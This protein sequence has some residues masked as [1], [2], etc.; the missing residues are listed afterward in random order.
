[1]IKVN[2][3]EQKERKKESAVSIFWTGGYDSTF[4]VV[5]LSR[6]NVE[7]QPI[8][9]SDNR[10][11]EPNELK[12]IED[13]THMLAKHP[14]TIATFCPLRIITKDQR[15]HDKEFNDAYLRISSKDYVGS[16]YVWL[17]CYA[18]KNNGIEMSIHRDDK[19]INIIQKYG[20]L[21]KITDDVIGEYYVID[22]ENSPADIVKLWGFL[23][24]P[25]ADY[26][27]LQMKE[28]YNKEGYTDVAN[29]T[30][31]CHH[32]KNGKPCGTCA[33]CRYTIEEGLKERF[34]V[35]ALCRYYFYN[36]PITGT[37]LKVLHKIKH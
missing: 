23:R 4:R 21:K 10:D 36:N 13:I 12:A 15:G 1:M 24:F 26:T 5:Q 7:I 6:C 32:P 17:G 25:L 2:N 34:T 29:A 28:F 27:K 18:E 33:P 31:F 11:C 8:Y 20:Q 9:V 14:A 35:A 3:M 30:W 22:S 16:Q 19:A 37:L